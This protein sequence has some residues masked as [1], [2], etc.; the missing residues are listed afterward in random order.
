MYKVISRILP[1]GK[2][3][4][5]SRC[6]ATQRTIIT[7]EDRSDKPNRLANLKK[8]WFGKYLN[9]IKKYESTLQQKFPRTIHMYR[10]FSVGSKEVYNDMKR[11]FAVSMKQGS[12]GM[13]SLTREELQ[14]LYTVPKDAHKLLPLLLLTTIPFTNYIIFP[15]ALYFPRYFLTSHFWTLQQKLEFML[16]D[17]K[18]RLGHN[19]PLLRCMQVELKTIKD[20]TLKIKWQDA[21]ACLGSGTHPSTKD[22]LA[23]RELFA[24]P[25]Y[26]L[27]VLKRKHLVNPLLYS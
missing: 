12:T 10:V 16:Q 13:G 26:S 6:S 3:L 1:R 25:P 27:S 21:V 20:Q 18:E 14:L 9:Y 8:Y 22:I 7:A 11:M 15:I 4:E 19:K 5:L 24:G 23:C 17:H 2:T